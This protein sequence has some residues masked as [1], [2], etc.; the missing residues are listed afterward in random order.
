MPLLISDEILQKAKL[1]EREA[2]IE[3]ACA[4]F[5]AERLSVHEAA[6]LAGMERYPFE[7]ELARRN[8]PIYRPTVEDVRHDV[9]VLERLQAK[10]VTSG[11]RRQ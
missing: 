10:R 1:T 7:E 4:L 9:E 11:D 2:L 5:D 6:R 3:F 8:I